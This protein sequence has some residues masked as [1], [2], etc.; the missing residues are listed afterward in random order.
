MSFSDLERSL[1]IATPPRLYACLCGYLRFSDLERSLGIATRA[2]V[3]ICA[4]RRGFSD[5]ER[6]LGIATRISLVGNPLGQK[7]Q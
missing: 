7:F 5:L 2:S 6:S 3:G 1:G 4:V